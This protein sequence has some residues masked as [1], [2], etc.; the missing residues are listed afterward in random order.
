M[1][2]E[3]CGHLVNDGGYEYPEYACE[4][5]GEDIPERF[6]TGEG[7]KATKRQRADRCREINGMA[8]N[9]R[10]LW[11]DESEENG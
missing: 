5:W 7:C 11:W 9:N 8:N 4:L 6:D 1:K 2:C 3:K 10:A